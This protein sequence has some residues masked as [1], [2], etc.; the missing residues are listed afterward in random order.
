MFWFRNTADKGDPIYEEGRMLL[1]PANSRAIRSARGPSQP[2]GHTRLAV[3]DW[4]GDGHL[5]L[6]I[7]DAWP[8]YSRA[9]RRGPSADETLATNSLLARYQTILR[10]CER[11]EWQREM[12]MWRLGRRP[13]GIFPRYY[14]KLQDDYQALDELEGR[15]EGALA[16]KSSHGFVWLLLRRAKASSRSSK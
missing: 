12:E 14:E 11:I 4:N 13:R 16:A 10:R 5:D 8:P 2:G 9:R 15:L 7:G 6:L 1:G 3:V